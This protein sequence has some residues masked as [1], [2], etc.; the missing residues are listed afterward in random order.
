VL[1]KKDKPNI[2]SIKL[3][4]Y[5]KCRD[6]YKWERVAKQL[7]ECP[8]ETLWREVPLSLLRATHIARFLKTIKMHSLHERVTFH[9]NKLASALSATKFLFINARVISQS[10]S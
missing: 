4:L 9:R 5:E 6:D 8:I 3:L 7:A 1:K 2:R 10:L